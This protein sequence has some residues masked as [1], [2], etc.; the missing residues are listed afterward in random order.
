MKRVLGDRAIE[1]AT[2]D[3]TR[4]DVDAVVN[5]ANAR[6]AP[7]GGVA[8]AIHRAA[9]PGLA[10]ACEPLGGCETGEAKITDGFDLPARWIVHTV[11]PVY[12]Q[13]QPARPLLEA[14]YRNSLARAD[15]AGAESIAFPALSTGAFGYPLDEA[16]EV[17]VTTLLAA[18]PAQHRLRPGAGGGGGCRWRGGGPAEPRRRRRLEHVA[19]PQ[20]RPARG[21][22]G[23]GLDLVPAQNWRDAGIAAHE[24][25]RPFVA[26]LPPEHVGIGRAAIRP[27]RGVVLRLAMLR[28][29]SRPVDQFGEEL[30]LQRP[31]GDVIAV[32][33]GIAAIEGRTPVEEVRLSRFCPMPPSKERVNEAHQR[34]HTVHHRGVDDLAPTGPLA[35]VESGEHSQQQEHGPAA[36]IGHEVQRRARRFSRPADRAQRAAERQVVDVVPGGLGKRPLLTPACHPAIDQRVRQVIGPEPKLFHDAGTEAL[37]QA[38]LAYGGLDHVVLTAGLYVSPD[39]KGRISD[40]AWDRTFDVNTKGAYLVADEAAERWAAQGLDGSMVITTS[41]NGVVS[42]TGSFA[43]DASKAAT[44]HLV[45][46]LAIEHAPEIR[47]NGLAPA[48]VVEGSSMFPRDR[49]MASL[50]KYG[51]DYDDSESTEALRERLARFYAE[52]TLTKKPIT[53]ADQAEAIFMLVSDA[54]LGKTTGQILTV[55]GGL[56]DAFLR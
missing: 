23:M 33:A 17:A 49:V 45:R 37:D 44:N 30:R 35:L 14:C 12:G 11:G 25:L 39:E 9:G 24:D 26:R 46:E 41:V 42:K 22:V 48:T 21:V 53:P 52:R 13:D 4:A 2:G 56:K 6:L 55:D 32:G 47:V 40:A 51:L 31:H 19:H 43:Y 15:E 8:G 1:I 54:R 16:A 5:A 50:D 20:E 3:I 38:M 27:C 36:V 34:R 29:Q 7:G 10:A 28:R 18:L